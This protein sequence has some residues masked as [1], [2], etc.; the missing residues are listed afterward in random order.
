[1]FSS[2]YF[3]CLLPYCLFEDR[4][5]ANPGIGWPEKDPS[6]LGN[7]MIHFFKMGHR[8]CAAVIISPQMQPL[9]G[10]APGVLITDSC[11]L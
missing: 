7:E 1:M 11:L 5:P 2:A 10:I 9:K 8:S 3:L 4:S 6:L